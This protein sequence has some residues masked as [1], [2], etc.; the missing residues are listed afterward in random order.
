M[1]SGIVG[2]F[3]YTNIAILK[4]FPATHI[5][6]TEDTIIIPMVVRISHVS[7]IWIGILSTM[8]AGVNR[9]MNDRI[10]IK[11]EFGFC[12]AGIARTIGKTR[13]RLA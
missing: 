9:G 7:G 11:G 10:L 5:I 2:R 3:P 4:I 8:N 1:S 13:M 6:P 12:I